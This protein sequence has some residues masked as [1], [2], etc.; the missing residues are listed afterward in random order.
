[1]KLYV[2][3]LV[4][5]VACFVI[6]VDSSQEIMKNL[7]LNFGKALESCKKDLDLPDE[8]SADF[9]NF[10][11]DGYQLSNRLT[12]CAI[13]CMSKKLDLLDPEGKM[14]HGNTMEFAKKH[15]AG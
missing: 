4:L 12:G 5:A 9:A 2:R 10:W 15:G 13:M 7:S 3:I 8:V 6:N 14:H 1:M 11:K